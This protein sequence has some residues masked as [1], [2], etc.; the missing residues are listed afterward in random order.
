MKK[1]LLTIISFIGVIVSTLVLAACNNEPVI[2]DSIQNDYG[3]II[4]GG[5][6]EEGSTLVT[7][8]VDQ[9]SDEAKDVLD[10]LSNQEYNKNG[11]VHIFDIYVSKDDKKIQPD[12]KVKVTIPV[13]EFVNENCFVFHIKENKSVE[14]II[15]TFLEGKII[16]ETSSFSYFVIV[17]E[18]NE[19]HVHSFTDWY[20]CQTV[21]DK[22]QR[23]CNCGETETEECTYDEGKVTKEPSHFEE[24]IKTY[25]CT[26]CGITK[27]EPTEK[28]TEHLF[29]D[30]Y[31][32]QTVE[33]QHERLC[34]CGETENGKCTYDE[35]KVTKEPTHFEEGITT[36]TCTVCGRTKE[37]PIEKTTEHLFGDWYPSHTVEDQHERS[38][39]CGETET[40]E[41]TY[42]EGKVTKEPSHFEEGIKTYTCTVCGRTKEEPIEKTTEHLFGDW[43]PS[44]TVEDKHQRSCNCGETET[45]KCTYDEGKVTKEPSH[46][47]E[48]IKTYTCTVCGRTKE[49]PIEKTTEHLFG[50]WY[51]SQ[52]E[53]DKHERLCKCGETETGKCTYDEGKVT[54]EPSHLEE[55][56]KTYTCTVC[57]R[58]K[59]EPIEKTTEHLFGDWHPSQ[60]EED[61]HERLCRCGETETGE[62][63]YDDG[64][65]DE[66]NGLIIYTC[67][68][69]GR[70]KA[71]IVESV[72]GIIIVVAGGTATFE[73]KETVISNSKIYGE[74]VNVY[75]AQENDVLNVKLNDQ[76]GRTFKYWVSATGT[77][78]PDE[79][80]SLLV[81]RSGYYYPVFEDTD[82]SDFSKRELI[83]EGNCE[84]G[85][86]Y[87]SSNSKGDIK[88]EV[89][90]LNGGHHDFYSAVPFNN[91]Y[92]K[93]ECDVCGEV[94]Y[95]EHYEYDSYIEKEANHAEEGIMKFECECGHVWTESIP[96]TDEHSIDYDDWHIV[97]ESLDGNYG[98]YRV[99]CEYCD[100]YEEYWYLGNL[101]FIGF[102]E[103]KMI[104]YQYT[105]GGKVCHDE[106][107]YSYRNAAG[108]KVYIWAL[109][110]QYEYSTNS[111]YNDTYIFM[112]IDDEDSTTLEP[113]YLSKSKGDGRGEYLWAIYGYAYDVN[114]W[115]KT[116]DSPD[117]NIGCSDGMLLSNSMSARSSV[118]Q[119]YYN[120]WA[121]TYNE[122]RIPTSKSYNDLSGTSWEIDFEG[123]SFQ[124]GYYD[125]N[126]E[127]VL[128]GGRDVISYVKDKGTSYKKY[129]YVDKET[130]ITYGYEDLGTYYRT[131]FIMRKYKEIVSPEEYEKLDEAGKSLVYSYGDIEKDIK[132]LCSKRNS[133]NNF[134]LTL[135]ETTNAFRL[136][137][138]DPFDCVEISGS[139]VNVYNNS[140]YVYNSGNPITF[141][142]EGKEGIAFDRYEIWDFEN[143]KWITLSE[144]ATYVFNSS[145]DPR[146]DAA[147]IRVICHEVEVPVEPTELFRIS[148]ENGYFE[149]DDELYYGT[150]EVPANTHVYV[151]ANDVDGKTFEYWIDGN[152]DKFNNY[153]FYVT[154]D[155]T[156]TPVYTDTIYN[157]YCEGW[158]YDC[159]VSI[160]GGETYFTTEIEGKEGTTF[161][162]STTPIP[163][164]ECNVFLGW[165]LEIYGNNGIEYILISDKQTFTFTITS[166][167]SG[168]L[169]AVWTTGEN[170]F[171][172]KYVDIRVT[173]GFVSYAGGEA[174]EN[175]DNAYSAISLSSY[176]RVNFYD[177]PTDETVYTAW[178]IAYRYELEGEVLH[179]FAESFE[180]EYDF[181]PAEYWVDDPQYNYP[182]GVINVTGTDNP[183]YE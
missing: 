135:P 81:F 40:E 22:H 71:E 98:K 46:L 66:E 182:D 104:N 50:D 117:Y 42:D 2:L 80:F 12:G 107:Y 60:T 165:Y 9:L 37:E 45:G 178:D 82:T 158:N 57:G 5:K 88:Y 52:T 21:E 18:Q 90:F 32:S 30:W 133:F 97:E 102:M 87:M 150:V 17:E 73:G 77:I 145:T 8:S 143:Q 99:Y 131:I 146:R 78:I 89:E 179:Q 109:Q 167:E 137:F 53:E 153:H 124:G 7:N 152:G 10:I 4:E 160:N 132:S 19:E 127:Y 138:S 174:S 59:E 164:G 103:N 154:S 123:Q 122:L 48:G 162:L 54:K 157:Q 161:E 44:Q 142:W 106:Y 116:L 13:P 3:V 115:I 100:Y 108:Q 70:E 156:L 25:T 144:N 181:Y 128:T 177:D 134:T 75:I 129:M 68:I 49:E 36:Y 47:E 39:N 96:V 170:P 112:Y 183:I 29:G 16:F 26:V 114:D 33:D 62:C 76:N 169:Y 101:D 34:K 149:I 35:G 121:E 119:S 147:Y 79:D 125:E 83:F 141:T 159:Y 55:G 86:L 64:S 180:D 92:H 61:K 166:E 120:Y 113:I 173:N 72:E 51:P 58:T 65:T 93:I 84:E 172:K 91:Q 1:T 175:F 23:S 43:Y 41:C 126:D 148:V 139:N 63:T 94:I 74:N 118:F 130:G 11:N 24:G 140:A 95:E 15:P 14:K 56:I 20:P 136:L 151:Y 155:M 168:F 105:Y 111:D 176:G 171:I 31:P 69:C 28:T 67:T 6:F 85:N 38:C 163:D 27:E 110:Y